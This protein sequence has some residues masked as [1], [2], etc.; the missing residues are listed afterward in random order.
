M[1]VLP[2]WTAVQTPLAGALEEGAVG[3]QWS[4]GRPAGLPDRSPAPSAQTVW[5]VGRGRWA[6]AGGGG[7][8]GDDVSG[9]LG[10]T[11][12][13]RLFAST[14]SSHMFLS[15][16]VFPSFLSL[17]YLILFSTI[18]MGF[19]HSPDTSRGLHLSAC[20]APFLTEPTCSAHAGQD[21]SPFLP[22]C[23]SKLMCTHAHWML[24][25]ALAS[26]IRGLC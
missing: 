25:F 17:R 21:L 13:K 12:S 1:G 22:F 3:R 4:Y 20:T 7:G 26:P 8:C 23:V 2:F 24:M 16:L 15:F 11:G 10:P 6:G 18:S 19:P 5:P 9:D 14:V